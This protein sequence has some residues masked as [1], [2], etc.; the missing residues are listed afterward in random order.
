MI[1]DCLSCN[2]GILNPSKP[3][4]IIPKCANC[5]TTTDSSWSVKQFGD[6]FLISSLNFKKTKCMD[7]NQEL[8]GHGKMCKFIPS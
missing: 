7:S 2:K 5:G 4:V 6:E 3:N 1:L 8:V